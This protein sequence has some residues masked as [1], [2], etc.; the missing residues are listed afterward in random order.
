MDAIFRQNTGTTYPLLLKGSPVGNLYGFDRSNY[1]IVDHLGVLRYRSSGSI[2]RR[3]DD[4]A[5][6]NAIGLA[7]EDLEIA[8]EAEA[9]AQEPPLEPETPPIDDEPADDE[10]D[11]QTPM[12][13]NPMM[14]ADDGAPNPE[15]GEEE[16]E[17]DTG[18]RSYS[19]GQ[20]KHGIEPTAR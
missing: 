20:I 14:P 4:R 18:M 13:P 1:A 17:T 3:Y 10:T 16:M 19:W 2:S 12:E 15:P 7:L 5:V 11:G 8:R 9:E 6:R